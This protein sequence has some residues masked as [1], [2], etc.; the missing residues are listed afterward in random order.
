MGAAGGLGLSEP[1]VP[2]G[3][4]CFFSLLLPATSTQTLKKHLEKELPSPSGS[5]P[6]ALQALLIPQNPIKLAF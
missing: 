5:V 3:H 4:H 2:L 6:R 1:G